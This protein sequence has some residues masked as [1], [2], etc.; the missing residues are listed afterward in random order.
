MGTELSRRGFEL[1]APLWGARAIRDS[2]QLVVDV[3]AEYVAAGA[4]L[5]TTASFGLDAAHASLAEDAVGLA[6]RAGP[7]LPCVGSI[8]PADPTD[9]AQ[10]QRHHYRTLG[11]AL[12]DGGATSLF[13]ETHTSLKGARLAV[14]SLRGLGLP[15]WVALACGP[16]GKTLAG[17]P[18]TAPLGADVAFVGCSEHAGLRP[19]LQA[20]SRENPILAVRPSLAAT[21]EQGFD[22]SG[23]TE[24]EVVD[25]I[26][27]CRSEFTLAYVGG[28]CGTTPSFTA[29]LARSLRA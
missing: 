3:H 12:R 16:N 29:A 18:L 7:K 15:V 14:E 19:A 2:P 13:A 22:P 21:T 27:R 28:C 26:T 6:R 1:R 5:L 8:G 17:E 20:L 24:P 9:G 25:A 4:Q 11:R 23:A 10:Q